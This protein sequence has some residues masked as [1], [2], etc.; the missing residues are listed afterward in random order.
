MILAWLSA[1][2]G[3]MILAWYSA[4]RDIMILAWLSAIRN[5]MILAWLS[6]IRDIMNLAWYSTIRDI[7]I[8]AWPSAI[9]DIMIL[10]WY[11]AIRDIM[12]LAWYSAIRDI[13]ILVW[14]SA[15][16]DSSQHDSALPGKAVSMTLRCTGKQS[17]WLRTVLDS[18][19]LDLTISWKINKIKLLK[20][21]R[22]NNTKVCN[23]T[24]CSHAEE[25]MA[26]RKLG[27]RAGRN[28]WCFYFNAH[29]SKICK[30]ARYKIYEGESEK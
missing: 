25:T 20:K 17:A 27:M 7:M 24:R 2:R 5:I 8:L 1:I 9:R 18:V 16:Q 21:I 4:I 14:L 10:A 15:D 6:A 30:N 29:W 11:C 23:S 22:N 12:I 13:M 26:W 3:I 19:Q 28:I